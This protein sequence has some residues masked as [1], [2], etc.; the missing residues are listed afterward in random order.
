[1]KRSILLITGCGGWF[2]NTFLNY[3]SKSSIAKKV[4]MIICSSFYK[5]DIKNIQE[6]KNNFAKKEIKIIAG[7]IGKDN[8]YYNL[9]KIISKED[10]LYIVYSSSVIHAKSA[11]EFFRVNFFSL[12]KFIQNINIFNINKIVYISSNSPFGFS[13]NNKKFD[14]DSKYSPIGNYGKTKMLAEKYLLEAFPNNNLVIIRP[15]WFHGPNMPERQKLFLKKVSKGS[16]PLV[17]PGNNKRSIINTL[18]LSKA[19]IN[20]LFKKNKYK[21]YCICEPK[22]IS[23]KRFIE[24]IQNAS[25]NTNDQKK[26][27]SFFIS[28]ICLPPL[29]STIFSKLDIIIQKFGLYSKIIHVISELGMNIEM[30]PTKYCNE[31]KDHIFTSIESSIDNELKEAFEK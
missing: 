30:D 3:F 21:I 31:F 24:I 22:S 13:Q 17:L 29:T 26:Y 2:G 27:K 15:P 5:N 8:F 23:M 20:L 19:T 14:E 11:N 25:N 1:M 18:D 7:D 12:K 9:E 6:I 10:Q 16:F 28:A 4:D